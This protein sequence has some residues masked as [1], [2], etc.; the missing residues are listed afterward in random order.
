MYTAIRMSFLFLLTVSQ[1]LSFAQPIP[2]NDEQ[3]LLFSSNITRQG[4]DVNEFSA[5]GKIKQMSAVIQ[6]KTIAEVYLIG[7]HQMLPVR[8]I[9]KT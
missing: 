1:L 6:N 8:D 4:N 7:G 3:I 2:L 5:G 9:W